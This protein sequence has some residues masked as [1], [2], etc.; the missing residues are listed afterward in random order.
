MRLYIRCA[1]HKPWF[2]RVFDF[3]PWRPLPTPEGPAEDRGDLKRKVRILVDESLGRGVADQLRYVGYN[4]VFAA[5]VG[6]KGK[7]DK[8]VTSY[9]WRENRVIWTHDA[10][11]L[12][13]RLLPEHRN[14]G[15]VVLPGGDGDQR[16]MIVG[17]AVAITVF[18]HGPQTWRRSKSTIS[19]TGE[20]TIR[21]RDHSTGA[22]TSTRYRITKGEF[23][24]IWGDD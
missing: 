21:S 13:D 22:M 14:P 3:M 10:D 19:P 18:G 7:D 4:A 17:L 6:L 20:M 8:A 2:P 11:F 1:S 12:D 23:A 15:V 24:E 16:A 9:G 5:D